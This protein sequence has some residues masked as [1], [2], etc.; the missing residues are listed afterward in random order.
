MAPAVIQSLTQP[1]SSLSL[2]WCLRSRSLSNY[3]CYQQ[4][5]V[6]QLCTSLYYKIHISS[7]AMSVCTT[8]VVM[9]CLVP[10]NIFLR[11]S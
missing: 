4:I 11:L 1:W 9:Q 6:I 10:I 7:I 2:G 8:V 3:S 5:Y